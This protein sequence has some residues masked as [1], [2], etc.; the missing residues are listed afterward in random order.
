M[1]HWIEWTIL[2]V[3]IVTATGFVVWKVVRQLFF[4]RGQ[5][6]ACST[7]CSC[8]TV[9]S[10]DS[11]YHGASVDREPAPVGPERTSDPR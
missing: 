10:T 11:S 4:D 5:C 6:R 3:G 1:N 7:D 2:T 8:E 9:T